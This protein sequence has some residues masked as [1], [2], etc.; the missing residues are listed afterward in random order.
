MREKRQILLTEEFQIILSRYLLL[1][2][3]LECRLD[4]VTPSQSTEKVKTVT[5]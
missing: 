4:L 5:L 3:P 1:C 2:I